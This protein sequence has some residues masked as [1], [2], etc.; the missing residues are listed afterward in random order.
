R[1]PEVAV[2][3]APGLADYA[4]PDPAE[5]REEPGEGLLRHEPHRVAAR[6][7]DP[8]DGDE[9][10]L[11]GRLLEE[12]VERELDVGGRQLLAVVEAH[13]LAELERPRE[14]V[15]AHAPGLGQLRHRV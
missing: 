7:L 5:G 10:G 1:T 8:V 15:R 9:I 11:P 6:R 4:A 3:R 2:P 13:A 12:P 14:A